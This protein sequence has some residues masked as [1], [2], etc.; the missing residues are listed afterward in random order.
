MTW[1]LLIWLAGKTAPPMVVATYSTE[2]ACMQNAARLD[3]P[4]MRAVCFEG[5]PYVPNAHR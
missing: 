5:K 4:V 1:M 2:A 3:T